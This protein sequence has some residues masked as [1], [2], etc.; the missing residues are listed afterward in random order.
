[1]SVEV[2]QNRPL[3]GGQD[4][5][6]PAPNDGSSLAGSYGQGSEELPQ[7]EGSG[8]RRGGAPR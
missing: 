5:Q 6:I 4:G 2:A 8:C 1:M 7:T 3:D